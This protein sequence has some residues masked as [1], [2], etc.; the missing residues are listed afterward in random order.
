MI[1]GALLGFL[2][3]PILLRELGASGFG[4]WALILAAAGYLGLLELGL[5]FAT[6]TRVAASEH[7]GPE[8]LGRLMSTSLTLFSGIA[9]CGVVLSGAFCLVF[10]QLFGLSPELADSARLAMFL[11]G[12]WQSVAFVV[13]GYS[14]A[15]LGTGRMYVVN[16]SGFAVASLISIVQVVLVLLG[17]GLA[18]LA[19]AQLA[20]GLVTLIVFRRQIRRAMPDV[21]VTLGRLDRR[22]ARR[23][24]SLGWRNSVISVAST[25]AFGSDIVLVGL[26]LNPIA[27]AAYAVALRGYTLLQRITT[28]VL[29]P[30]GPA[31]AHAAVTASG[32]R[33][34]DLF[35]VAL[36][37]TLV[38]ALVTGLTVATFAQPLLNLWLG[39]VPPHAGSVLVILCAVLILQSPGMNAAS[40]LMNSEEASILMRITVVA[41]AANVAGSIAFTIWLGTIGPALGSLCAVAF[42][43]ALYLPRHVC[44]LL[45]QHARTLISRVIVPIM[46]PV[47]VLAIVL[48][49][50]RAL[51]STGPGVLVAAAVSLAAFTGTAAMTPAGRELVSML[52]GRARR[53]R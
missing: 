33:R 51:V 27:A 21:V 29:G 1:L 45:G 38:L 8:E 5:G 53:N 30:M 37:V 36:R 24:L 19:A 48:A 43:D 32:E 41:A 18:Q 16:F 20:G 34:F 12:T 7:R 4:T 25:L 47:A 44:R 13:A 39:D 52:P 50:T 15:L 26:L 11:A 23:L 35:C 3:T 14:A 46:A 31:H 17:G 40:L 22:V 9:A 6:I 42:F 10:P 49:G 2:V 28:G